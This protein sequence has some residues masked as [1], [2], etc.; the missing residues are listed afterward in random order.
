MSLIP[1]GAETIFIW[2]LSPLSSVNEK[3]TGDGERKGTHMVSSL[4]LPIVVPLTQ[5]THA[6]AGKLGKPSLQEVEQSAQTLFTLLPGMSDMS[7]T[8][9]SMS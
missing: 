9:S 3:E 5:A 1:Q 6:A 4:A 2:R 8:L 7:H